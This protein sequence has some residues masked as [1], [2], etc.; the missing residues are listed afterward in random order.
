M[1]DSN[2]HHEIKGEITELLRD[3][4]AGSKRAES[5]LLIL[6]ESELKRMAHQYLVRE[7]NRNLTLRTT[8]M[9][10][11]LYLRLSS[12]QARIDWKNR[13][14]FFGIA[15]RLFRQ[16]LVDAFRAKRSRKRGGGLA[17]LCFESNLIPVPGRNL[18]IMR[19]E[20]ALQE[21]ERHDARK[22]RIV[23]LK[24]YGGLTVNEIAELMNLSTATVKRGWA[25]AKAWL[26]EYLQEQEIA[27]DPGENGG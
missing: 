21:L 13:N 22:G 6:V 8:E 4:Q 17:N 11:E 7:S 15:A 2:S 20:E 5:R 18:D 27:P 14:Q 10:H 25:L 23:V 12:Q 16:I 26:W 24:F 3:W 1:A 9:F 19:L